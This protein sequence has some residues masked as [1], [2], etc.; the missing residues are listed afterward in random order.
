M[1]NFL[2]EIAKKVY[3]NYG[4]GLDRICMVFPNRRASLFFS[5]YLSEITT[6][7]IWSP[8]FKT[9][10]ELM[11]DLSDIQGA[12]NLELVFE[13]YK[14][15]RKETSTAESF[16]E[17]YYWGE[18]LLNDFDDIDKYLVNAS[19]LFHNLEALKEMEDHLEYLSD[20]QMEAIKSF[21]KN[22][23]P[24]KATRHKTDFIQ[25]WPLLSKVYSRLRSALLKKSRGYEGM[26]YRE[27]GERIRK[28]QPFDL[29]FDI[30]IMVGF[31]ALNPCEDQL[32]DFLRKKQMAEFY[33]DYDEAYLQDETKEAGYFIRKNIRRF[34]PA[35]IDFSFSHLESKDKRV[36]ILA[37]P[38]DVGQAKL[39]PQILQQIPDTEKKEFHHTAIVLADEQ[40]LMPVIYSIPPEIG[41]INVTMG[42]PL[43]DTPLYSLVIHLIELQRRKRNF[44]EGS[45][46][47][48]HK[49]VLSILSHQYLLNQDIPELRGLIK[50]IITGNR[51][52]VDATL[53]NDNELLNMI[54]RDIKT[55]ELMSDY[56]MGILL[57]LFNKLHPEDDQETKKPAL[58]QEYLFHLY[59]GIQQLGIIIK[60]E[61]ITLNLETYLKLLDKLVKN[62]KI[63]FTGEPLAGLQVMGI[64]ET[65]A[66][67]FEN[68]ILLSVNEGVLPGGKTPASFIPY[69]LRKGFGLPTAEHQD[70]IYSYYFYRLI[71]RAKNVTL[72]Y[73]S[74][75]EGLKSGEMSRFLTQLKYNPTI[76]LVEKVLGFD[77]RI[78]S[79]LSTTIRKDDRIMQELMKYSGS[80]DGYPYLSPS[81]INN[82]LDCSLKFYYRYIAGLKESDEISEEI[83]FQIFGNILHKA[84]NLLYAPF[85]NR[86]LEQ[87]QLQ[88][89]TQDQS[90]IH[91]VLEKSMLAEFG[92][93]SNISKNQN[94]GGR[95]VVI[96]EVLK[97]YISQILSVDMK[98]LP[99][100]ILHLEKEFKACIYPD[101][102]GT[103][104]PI[105]IGGTIDRIDRS[106]DVTRIIDYKTGKGD[107]SYS[108][109]ES[110][111]QK[112]NPKRNSAVFQTFMYTLLVSEKLSDQPIE[113]GLYY[114]RDLYIDPFNYQIQC[115]ESG[116]PD[117]RI[118]D[119]R[120]LKNDFE[121]LLNDLA[122]EMF[123]PAIPFL[124]V[125]DVDVC[126]LCSF[127]KI[128]HR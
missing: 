26:I 54:F 55:P 87:V 93:T 50:E 71:Q 116:M 70:S 95:N 96:I 20:S 108:G 6:A 76:K 123:N 52:F 1:D 4:K 128:C 16:D 75:S 47:F 17:F 2:L 61:E 22:L 100:E 19:D 79:P 59:L 115:K 109:L 105:R 112:G 80:S 32:F 97:K 118:G 60:D 62:I 122:D 18:M 37:V 43:R 86:Q 36:D 66:L 23:D 45:L 11:Q 46:F 39:I 119:F 126:K 38:S 28:D 83:D 107:L 68:L 124:Q 21:W 69:N 106:K 14:I 98:F 13:L 10:N 77:I 25:L 35:E 103:Q 82:Y 30:F 7:P 41:E 67:D 84:I 120:I 81:G 117:Q 49:P 110:L 63:P 121:R 56:L 8:A 48:Y 24:L 42:Y 113:P 94:K 104:I 101:H 12:E 9:I 73:N 111:F 58:H 31:N 85:E 88:E 33:W 127:R 92:R 5:K 40:L 53:F 72:I 114:V 74:N 99:L 125:E 51:I 15:F 65:R 91:D 44:S 90:K 64:L 57:F 27:V 102:S 89:M 34:P 29:D 3:Q 78:M